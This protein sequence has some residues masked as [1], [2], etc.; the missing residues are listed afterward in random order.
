MAK[1][2]EPIFGGRPWSESS[3]KYKTTL[4]NLNQAYIYATDNNDTE[5]LK[6]LEALNEKR[7]E[8]KDNFNVIDVG[9]GAGKKPKQYQKEYD[10]A[11]RAWVELAPK[12][13]DI[14]KQVSTKKASQEA[15]EKAKMD[16]EKK[17]AAARGAQKYLEKEKTETAKVEEKTVEPESTATEST[18]TESVAEEK[19]FKEKMA[20]NK[21]KA[22]QERL[23]RK[24]KR[25]LEAA[26]KKAAEQKRRRDNIIKRETEKGRQTIVVDE[27]PTITDENGNEKSINPR[28]IRKSGDGYIISIDS[29]VEFMSPA[30]REKFDALKADNAK[31]DEEIDELTKQL[32]EAQKNGKAETVSKL[33]KDIASLKTAKDINLVKLSE[34]ATLN[35]E[36]RKRD[37][38]NKG[39]YEKAADEYTKK[40]ETRKDA[41]ELAK[42]LPMYVG[43]AYKTGAFG[44]PNSR[45]AKATAAYFI[46]DRLAKGITDAGLVAR[47]IQP[48]NKSAWAEYSKKLMDQ[49]IERDSE[50]R[51]DILK[52]ENEFMTKLF[53]NVSA[54]AKD[55]LGKFKSEIADIYKKYADNVDEAMFMKLLSENSKVLANMSEDDRKKM[56]MLQA[57]K[58]GDIKDRAAAQNMQVLEDKLKLFNTSDNE[59]RK[60]ELQKTLSTELANKLTT[61]QLRQ[62]D[63]L[64]TKLSFE[65][66]IKAQEYE[67][68]KVRI[69]KLQADLKRT[70]QDTEFAFW[71]GTLGIISDVLG[72]PFEVVS[73][74]WK[75]D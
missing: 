66:Q 16:E 9:I 26:D 10:V 25:E 54:D 31:K 8:L 13:D 42:F 43:A 46:L 34:L 61:K 72:L 75:K 60:R 1:I 58:S 7:D 55:R 49:A 4:E 65:T 18:S 53:D 21:A 38:E 50:H 3:N 73:K 57:M 59:E 63:E 35:D 47:G 32:A 14:M 15:K 48:G 30:S 27:V 45:K 71:N 64:I 19:T 51:G 17:K 20:E 40:L 70:K 52:R 6:Q 24:A 2:K 33:E 28:Y 22:E 67:E 62:M 74:L 41:A 5:L 69:E 36:M 12:V 44:D 23:E 68:I 37:E 11:N 39:I 56:M 29:N